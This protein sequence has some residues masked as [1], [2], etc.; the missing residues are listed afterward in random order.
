MAQQSSV[1]WLVENAEDFFGHLLAPSIIEKAN[2][3]HKEEI[4]KTAI[5]CHFQ[6]VRQQ[7][8]NSKEYLDYGEQHYNELFKT[9]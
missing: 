3:M 5:Q 2:E 6:G 8:K 4:T 7:A 9:K 1:E